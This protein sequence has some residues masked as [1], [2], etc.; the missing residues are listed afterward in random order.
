MRGIKRRRGEEGGR[1]KRD[2]QLERQ[3]LSVRLRGV[4]VV[5][6]QRESR[7]VMIHLVSLYQLTFL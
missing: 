6:G 5:V 7:L 2:S 1:N 4:V 3:R